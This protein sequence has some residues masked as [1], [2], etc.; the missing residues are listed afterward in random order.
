MR[1][2]DRPDEP[3]NVHGSNKYIVVRIA[4]GEKYN[5]RWDLLR[6]VRGADRRLSEVLEKTPGS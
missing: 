2:S 5:G 3:K 6:P 1:K 4:S